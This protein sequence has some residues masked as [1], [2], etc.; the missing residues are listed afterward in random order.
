M[1][2]KAAAAMWSK[3]MQ[4]AEGPEG[5]Q[6]GYERMQMK[7]CDDAERLA[8]IE[9]LYNDPQ[10]ANLTRELSFTNAVLVD[11]CEPLFQSLKHWTMGSARRST[12]LLMAITRIAK[13]VQRMI[14][15][16]Y[17]QPP[18]VV[19][20]F[21]NSSQ[22]KHVLSLFSAL[23]TRLTGKSVR[24][25]YTSLDQSWDKYELECQLNGDYVVMNRTSGDE[26]T[27]KPEYT[28]WCAGKRCWKQVYKGFMCNHALLVC[29]RHMKESTDDSRAT[30]VNRVVTLCN[31]NWWRSTYSS[32][33]LPARLPTPPEIRQYRELS[34]FST[35]E[36]ALITR[37][38]NVMQFVSLK[39][40]SRA[41]SQLETLALRHSSE[42]NNNAP[43]VTNNRQVQRRRREL[44]RRSVRYSTPRKRRK[45]KLT[46]TVLI[47]F[48]D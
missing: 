21:F 12:T 41:L 48:S 29:L 14:C 36:K 38:Q 28:C 13:G 39:K 25:M 17:L 42:V 34:E 3:Y 6:Q 27:V 7:Y 20:R 22:N 1:F 32:S 24:S 43:V 23:C 44:I 45:K 33:E 15:R 40:V 35:N 5:F 4:Y 2:G 46:K 19:A 10:K 18:R 30:I 9:K 26:F 31:K 47:S 11:S 8:F 37:L 16:A